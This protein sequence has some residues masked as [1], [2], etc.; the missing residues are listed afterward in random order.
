MKL[1]DK[2]GTISLSITVV[3]MYLCITKLLPLIS[4]IWPIKFIGVFLAS[5]AIYRLI[6]MGAYFVLSKSL[7]LRKKLLGEEFIEG[8]W[9]GQ[10]RRIPIKYT[11]EEFRFRNGE[12]RLKASR[13]W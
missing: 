10:I 5:L 13:I 12:F 11:V 7:W 4:V 2:I 8:T 6:A 3:L 1:Q 9:V